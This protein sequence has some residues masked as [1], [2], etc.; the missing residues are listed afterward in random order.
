MRRL[1]FLIVFLAPVEI[2][3][4]QVDSFPT[5]TDTIIY[6]DA[7]NDSM[8][9][10]YDTRA[11]FPGGE[12]A[13]INFVKQNLSYPLS[14]I[15]DSVQGRV[16]LI[17][18]IDDNGFTNKSEFLKSLNSDIEIQCAKMIKKMPKWKPATQLTNSK[19]GWYW[20]PVI[21]WYLLNLDFSLNKNSKL[22]GIVIT[23]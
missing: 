21:S 11:E 9:N 16:A 1:L 19:K 13:L 20:R 23:P 3:I 14:A 4:A 2:L 17:F 6:N 8:W 18:C 15:N 12:N 7:I 5:Q 10:E 22:S